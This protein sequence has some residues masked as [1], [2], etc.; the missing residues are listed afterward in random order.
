MTRPLYI[1][2]EDCEIEL[3]CLPEHTPIHGNASAIDDETDAATERWIERQLA[4]GNDWAWCTV[5]VVA[6][7]GDFVGSSVLGCCSY[8]SERDFRRDGYYA[9]MVAEAVEDLNQSIGRAAV[10]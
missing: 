6:R 2:A 7:F 1:R 4:R 8:K 3:E 5:R 9:D 10:G